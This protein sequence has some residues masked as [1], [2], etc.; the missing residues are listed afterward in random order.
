MNDDLA[1]RWNE[2]VIWRELSTLTDGQKERLSKNLD[3]VKL[4]SGV[5]CLGTIDRRLLAEFLSKSENRLVKIKDFPSRLREMER[6]YG[7][8]FGL[9]IDFSDADVDVFSKRWGFNWLLVMLEGM[10]AN[11][12]FD[13][14]AERFPSWKFTADLDKMIASVRQPDH[15]YPF[16]LK[17]SEEAGEEHAY[18]SAERCAGEGLCAITLEER[19]LLEIWYHWKTGRHLDQASWTLCGGS[20]GIWGPK[21][22]YAICAYFLQGAFHVSWWHWDTKDGALRARE[23]FLPDGN[24]IIPKL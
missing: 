8:V 24:R 7:E 2:K 1:S 13:K 17:D 4:I 18:K 21:G 10:T 12:L 9:Q 11:R 23:I 5:S 22:K 16:L 19:L 14:C 6:F 3:L 20:R 15:T